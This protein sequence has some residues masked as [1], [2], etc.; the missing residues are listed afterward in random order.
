MADLRLRN[1]QNCW[2]GSFFHWAQ[3]LW[4][5]FK[6]VECADVLEMLVSYWVI[7]RIF[8]EREGEWEKDFFT[9][10]TP[11]RKICG[12]IFCFFYILKLNVL[13]FIQTVAT[14]YYFYVHVLT[15][16]QT[17]TFW[18]GLTPTALPSLAWLHDFLFSSLM[19]TEPRR[20]S[21]ILSCIKIRH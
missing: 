19:L 3:R 8:W 9:S 14:Y 21:V 15:S 20:S 13:D 6:W 10:H 12:F 16:V 4:G 5:A 17:E 1:V 11:A 2:T 18:K 7:N